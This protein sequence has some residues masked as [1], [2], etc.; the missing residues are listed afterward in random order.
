[1]N[2]EIPIGKGRKWLNRGG[3]WNAIFGGYDMVFFYRISSGNPLTFGMGGST[4][5]VHAGHRRHRSGRPNSTGQ[6]CPPAGR[7]DGHRRRSLD[8]GQP[9]QDDRVHGLLHLPGGLHRG[10]RGAKHHGPR[11]ASSSNEFSASKE[12]KVK[13][14]YT[15]QLRYDFQNPFKWYNLATPN[16]TVN[17]QQSR[18]FRHHHS[19]GRVRTG[20]RQRRRP[21]RYDHHRGVPLLG[22]RVWTVPNILG[23]VQGCEEGEPGL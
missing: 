18:H 22:A 7:L 19:V 15:F 2:Y 23:T 6:E 12:W 16:T 14:R 10:Q 8:P 4:V 20:F 17:F 21:A 11:S 1:M 5:Q 3:V 13:E 9:E